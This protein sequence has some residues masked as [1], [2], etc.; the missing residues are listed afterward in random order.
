MKLLFMALKNIVK[1][2]TMPIRNWSLAIHQ[3][4]IHFEGRI[5]I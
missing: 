5:Q 4:L 3:F 2:W 1:K